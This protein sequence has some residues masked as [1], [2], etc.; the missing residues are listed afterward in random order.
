MNEKIT[1]KVKDF[2]RVSLF[3]I[4]W[5]KLK[6]DYSLYL[7][8]DRDGKRIVKNLKGLNIS[9]KI[10]NWEKEKIILDKAHKKQIEYDEIYKIKKDIKTLK[11]SELNFV[12]YFKAK[13][14]RYE[15]NTYRNWEKSINNLV[16]FAGEN[17]AF[18]KI[19]RKFCNDFANYLKLERNLN[20]NTA[21]TYFAPFKKTIHETVDEEYLQHNPANSITFT[22]KPTKREYLT[23]RELNII[24]KTEFYDPRLKNAFL[25]SCY[26]GLRF[27]DINKITF[28]DV[29]EGR[30]SFV[31]QKTKRPLEIKLHPEALRI[32]EHQA[33][34]NGDR[35]DK[36]FQLP[37][38]EVCR[39]KIKKFIKLSGI[40]KN[41]TFHSAR[42]T[43]ATLC[44]TYDVPLNTVKELLGHKDIRNT[45][46]YAQLID[47]KKDQAIDK[48]PGL[49]TQDGE[50]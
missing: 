9:G 4:R 34:I 5:R 46:I 41:I 38:H 7:E 48:L 18:D 47:K 25:F 3:K 43:F 30:L 40:K 16:S 1:N 50:K 44:L 45:Q 14:N 15:G 10:S 17:I 2:N 19:D 35:K 32:I 37:C 11:L 39:S 20:I 8:L 13:A 21:G 27:V 28:L 12:D 49:I 26:T 22:R 24:A 23:E 31:Q 29:N 36:I 33:E 42:H 6:S